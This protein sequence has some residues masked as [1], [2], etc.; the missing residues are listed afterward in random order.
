M[1]SEQKEQQQL[2]PELRTET[3]LLLERIAAQQGGPYVESSIKAS[4]GFAV[5]VT[6]T[7]TLGFIT[8]IISELANYYEIKRHWSHYR[9]HPSVTPFAKFYGHDLTETM[10]FCV[11]QAVAA[12]APGVIRPIEEGV[13]KVMGVVDE[14]YEKAK[15]VEGGISQLV[16]GFERFVLEFANAMRTI[17]TR[18]RM[19]VIRIKEIFER[20]HGIFISFAFAAISAITFGENLI[21]NPLVTFIGTIAGVDVCC[22]APGTLVKT[23]EG[24]TKPIEAVRIGDHLWRSGEV[25]STYKFHGLLTPMVSI[26]GIVVS[27]NHYIWDD[28]VHG[29]VRADRHSEADICASV[30]VLYC[31]GTSSNWIPIVDASG[32]RVLMCADYEESSEPEV[33]AAAQ[34]AAETALNGFSGPT[35]QDYSLGLDPT[36]FVQMGDGSWILA[37]S[38]RIGD[39][40]ASG[41]W[42]VGIVTEECDS[43]CITPGYKMVSA[44]QLVQQEEGGP[45][46][47]A[48]HLWPTLGNYTRRLMHFITSDGGSLIVADS[49]DSTPYAVRDYQEW[50]GPEVQSIYDAAMIDIKQGASR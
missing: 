7:L 35:V 48:A 27:G 17:G 8:Y 9:C 2:S 41:A 12:H 36:L 45:W 22:F 30:P 37:D 20:V 6:I 11:G 4:P 33:V 28:A 15:S 39:V 32:Q 31:L 44:A 49:L 42:V 14:V 5:L 23:A 18:I 25:T 47:R 1:A 10:N 50:A 34:S 40:L 16:G 46:T 24:T 21:C 38:V 13:T 43:I 19:S 29:M 3:R 26:R